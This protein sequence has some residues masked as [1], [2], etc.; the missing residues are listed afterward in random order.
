MARVNATPRRLSRGKGGTARGRLG[1]G[2]LGRGLAV[3]GTRSGEVAPSILIEHLPCRGRDARHCEP[4]EVKVDNGERPGGR[5]G[6]EVART[7]AEDSLVLREASCAGRIHVSSAIMTTT[8]R[9]SGG[10]LLDRPESV[11]VVVSTGRSRSSRGSLHASP[12]CTVED[13]VGQP[14]TSPL[15]SVHGLSRAATDFATVFALSD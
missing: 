6:R 3:L 1:L 4:S 5:F 11:V 7:F 9:R 14:R 15:G 13:S 12:G 2:H 10:R 8:R